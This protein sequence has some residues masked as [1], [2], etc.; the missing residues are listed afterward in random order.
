MNEFEEAAEFARKKAQECADKIS[1]A[2]NPITELDAP[3]VLL[4]L[5]RFVST[6]EKTLDEEQKHIA[7]ILPTVLGVRE[8]VETIHNKVGGGQV[9]GLQ[10]LSLLRRIF[11]PRRKM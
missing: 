2:I 9:D 8:I 11:R 4:T 10:D 3:F 1:E 6:L 5:R 7:D